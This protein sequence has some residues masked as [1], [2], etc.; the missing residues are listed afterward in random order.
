MT[1]TS[2]APLQA[3]LLTAYATGAPNPWWAVLS[4]GAGRT[5]GNAVVLPT[6][7]DGTITV[8][9]SASTYLTVDVQGWIRS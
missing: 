1:L 8:Y 4:Y 9:S 3:G 6:G 2:V 5:V 7:P